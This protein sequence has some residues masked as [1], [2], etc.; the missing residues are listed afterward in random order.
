MR[1]HILIVEDD[2]F[3]QALLATVLKNEGF[4]ISLATSGEEMHGIL[5]GEPVHLI[6]L[7]LGL[8][9]EDGL[10]LARQLRARSSLPIIV[11]TGRQELD[12]KLAAL[13]IGADD[14]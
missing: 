12:D 2:E 1:P 5:A 4:R 7:D 11:L 3:I 8:P 13:E 14:T 9:D 6:L 10:T